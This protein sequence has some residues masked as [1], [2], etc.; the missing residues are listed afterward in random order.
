MVNSCGMWALPGP[1][2]NE[3]EVAGGGCRAKLQMPK[4]PHGMDSRR[5][6]GKKR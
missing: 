3:D 1:G 6:L 5:L 2:V 4:Q